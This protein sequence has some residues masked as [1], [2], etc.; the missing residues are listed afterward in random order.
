MTG[1]VLGTNITVV[2]KTDMVSVHV[3]FTTKSGC[4]KYVIIGRCDDL[5]VLSES[6]GGAR[7]F[8]NYRSI[9]EHIEL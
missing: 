5:R 9:S 3:K 1:N 4:V 8:F 6:V 7:F 2:N